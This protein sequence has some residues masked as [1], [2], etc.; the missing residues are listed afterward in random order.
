MSYNFFYREMKNQNFKNKKFRNQIN[1]PKVK[2]RKDLRKEKRLQEKVKRHNNFIQR[3]K[4]KNKKFTGESKK[5][6]KK[7]KSDDFYDEEDEEIPSDFED[8]DNELTDDVTKSA[9]DISIEKNSNKTQLEIDRMKDMEEQ[10][11]YENE[12][13]KKRIEQ[14][15]ESNEDDDKIIKKYEKLLKLNKRK[16]KTDVPLSFNDGLDYALELCTPENIQ[17]M[18]TAAKEAAELE[19]D[20]DND[21]IDDLD[22]ATGKSSKGKRK[23][24]N[25]VLKTQGNKTLKKMEKLKETEK[26]YFGE[27]LDEFDSLQGSDSEFDEDD[28]DGDE[29][30]QLD[31]N[32]A[33]FPSDSEVDDSGSDVEEEPINKKS[34]NGKQVNFNLKEN[35]SYE[36]ERTLEKTKADNKSKPKLQKEISVEYDS[37]EDVDENSDGESSEDLHEEDEIDEENSGSENSEVVETSSLKNTGEA[38]DWEDIYGRKRD[39]DGNILQVIMVIVTYFF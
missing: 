15:M 1:K 33:E 34:K 37:T 6:D 32:D 10:K 36:I 21:F 24:S 22:F 18:Y 39:K 14:M 23:F 9:K 8:L 4:F 20:S 29:D 12:M 25:N 13:K 2:T 7:E 35:K 28:D 38:K 30:E 26:K 27:D 16:S 17:K 19:E 11:E 3:Q 5:A 31:D